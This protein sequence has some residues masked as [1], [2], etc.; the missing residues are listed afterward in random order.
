MM[1]PLAAAAALLAACRPLGGP[2]EGDLVDIRDVDP[3][4]V[5]DIRYATENNF[6][7]TVLYPT[8]RCL[9]RRPAA[10]RLRLVASDLE[11]QGLRLKVWDC[12][13]PLSIQRR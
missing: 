13:R 3:R 10:E 9:L 4:V 12:Y 2:A 6:M 11:P 5:V 8:A 1:L 7:K